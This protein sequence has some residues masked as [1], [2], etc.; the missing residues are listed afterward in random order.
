MPQPI[1]GGAS[2]INIYGAVE[3]QSVY[4]PNALTG[5]PNHLGI[6]IV[7]PLLDLAAGLPAAAERRTGCGASSRSCSAFL[8][9]VE[10]ATLSR[11]GL[12]GLGCG[13]LVLALPYRRRLALARPARPARRPRS[14]SSGS[15]S[16]RDS[17]SSRR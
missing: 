15:S 17:T 9:I 11:S 10:L 8:L 7:V 2:S 6:M 16:S 4:R 3:G 13:L 1:T 14:R 5:D 12:L